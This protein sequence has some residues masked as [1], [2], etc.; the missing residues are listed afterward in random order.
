MTAQINAFNP[1]KTVRAGGKILDLS[2]PRVMGVVNVTPDSFY[3]GSRL[4]DAAAIAGRV[5]EMLEQGADIID[6]GGYSS[7]PGAEVIG[8]DEELSRVMPAVEAILHAFPE[9]FVSID[10]FRAEV[11]ARALA[12][13]AS[14]VNDISGG[15]LDEHMFETVAE[16]G[17]SYVLM[18]MRGNPGNMQQLSR[19]DQPIQAALSAYFH[20]RIARLRQ[21]G[22]SDILLDP[23]FGFAKTIE[24]NYDL[25]R[26]IEYFKFFGLPVLVGLSRKSMIYKVLGISPDEGLNGTSALH[27]AAL[28]KGA[29]ILRTHDVSAAVEVI[30]LYRKI[31]Q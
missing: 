10:T 4:E 12:A 8:V 19:Y 25:L 24:Q 7:R 29:S 26:N 31:V 23:G 11:A 18:H 17:S 22:V 5:G 30:R 13:G 16:T 2:L 6:I 14:M 15:Q 21:L 20:P 3:S 27:M 1:K 9:C 28:L